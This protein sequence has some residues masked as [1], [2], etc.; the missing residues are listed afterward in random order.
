MRATDVRKT[1]IIRSNLNPEWNSVFTYQILGNTKFI[2]TA[3]DEV[4]T[5][6][7]PK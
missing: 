2:L 7:Y 4:C 1:K 3:M 5:L 6:Y